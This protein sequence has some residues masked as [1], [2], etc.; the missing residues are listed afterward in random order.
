MTVS[1]PLEMVPGD[2]IEAYLDGLLDQPELP[3]KAGCSGCRGGEAAGD[4]VP[5][6]STHVQLPTTWCDCVLERGFEHVEKLITAG[7]LVL[8]TDGRLLDNLT[9]LPLKEI[10]TGADTPRKGL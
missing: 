9:T 4:W 8:T 1:T 5:Y 6:G 2:V 3:F 10:V 7:E